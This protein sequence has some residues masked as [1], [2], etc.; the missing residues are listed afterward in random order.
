MERRKCL[1]HSGIFPTEANPQQPF[2]VE[3]L[4]EAC[5]LDKAL[6]SCMRQEKFLDKG[7]SS[8][9]PRTCMPRFA[10]NHLL[11]FC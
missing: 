7:F 2:N 5:H 1:S 6:L 9:V 11:K 4:K 8:A 10:Y 3:S